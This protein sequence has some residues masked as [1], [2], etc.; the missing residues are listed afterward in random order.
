MP[1]QRFGY[2]Y[3]N[4]SYI[5]GTHIDAQ[6]S[7]RVRRPRRLA[8][9]PRGR[10]AERRCTDL[11]CRNPQGAS[12]ARV[13]V[14]AASRFRA[15]PTRD[16]RAT[17]RGGAP[18]APRAGAAD[19][20]AAVFRSRRP[21]SASSGVGYPPAA[22]APR[23]SADV[24]GR[25]GTPR[26]T[27]GSSRSA[28]TADIPVHRGAVPRQPDGSQAAPGP[29]RG[30]LEVPGYRRAPSASQTAPGAPRLPTGR[31]PLRIDSCL[32]ARPE[33]IAAQSSIAAAVCR[34]NARFPTA[35]RRTPG[36]LTA[37][38]Q[39]RAA[40]ARALPPVVPILPGSHRAPRHTS[41]S[42]T[43]SAGTRGRAAGRRPITGRGTFARRSAPSRRITLA[44]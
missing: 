32:R 33:T 16:S 29:D 14:T 38:A 24:I 5:G 8:I 20:A 3:V 10:R 42:A 1:H 23:E 7:R 35:V 18:E 30:R 28:D 19:D 43:A 27:A 37:I 25:M 31:G 2:G 26:E 15:G 40:P 4:S 6:Y 22:R 12:P 41:A 9:V 11:R 17:A 34:P 13:P 36:A 39:F 21:S 44:R